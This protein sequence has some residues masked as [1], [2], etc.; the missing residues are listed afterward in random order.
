MNP[1]IKEGDIFHHG[2]LGQIWLAYREQ[3]GARLRAKIISRDS[4]AGYSEQVS[5]LGI[6]LEGN[7]TQVIGNIKVKP[8]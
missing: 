7:G 4:G 5:D 6:G 1:K 8:F 3:K 2:M